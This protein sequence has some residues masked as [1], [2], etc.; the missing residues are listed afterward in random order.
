ME[1]MDRYSA[2]APTRWTIVQ[3]AA[4]AQSAETDAA[5]ENLCQT[6]WPPLYYYVRRRG[7]NVNDAQDLT[8]AFFQRLLEKRYLAAVD[9]RKGKFRSFLLATLEHF[10]A[11]EWRNSRA[12]KRGGHVNFISYEFLIEGGGEET[13]LDVSQAEKMFE[14]EWAT[15]LLNRVLARLESD[16]A[17]N[18]RLALF[19]DIKSVIAGKSPEISY[20]QIAANHKMT[21][22]AVK[23]AVHR[24]R[25]RYGELLLEEVSNTVSSP[26]DVDD[27][28]RA[29]Y[30]AL[31]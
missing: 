12:Q 30:A 4:D 19:T 22:A 15:T 26:A 20:A 11:N 3:H 21:E 2:F 1:T 18:G 31:S 7:Y 25:K 17:E 16:F 13:A 14:R 9:R 28:M 27:E 8:Q 24:L 5:L 23:M 29:L 10:L 6:Y